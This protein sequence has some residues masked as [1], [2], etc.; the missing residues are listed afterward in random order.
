MQATWDSL[1]R[2][3]PALL[4]S[5]ATA[6]AAQ[7]GPIESLTGL[8][9]LG[10]FSGTFDYSWI[11]ENHGV[12]DIMLT[13]TSPKDRGGFL[14]AL[15]FKNPNDWITGVQ[16]TASQSQWKLMGLSSWFKNG[17]KAAPFGNFDLGV[18]L[19]ASNWEGGGS[20]QKGI[21]VGQSV[22]FSFMLTGQHLDLPNT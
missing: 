14:P 19:N 9:K 11:D 13:N 2:L 7:A 4:L 1:R 12:V 18:G 20:P 22:K 10:S 8:Q 5:L 17:V 3:I 15:A 16:F 6:A 21:G